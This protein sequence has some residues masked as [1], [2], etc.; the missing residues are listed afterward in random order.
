MHDT[1]G[2]S[3]ICRILT[4]E[5][6]ALGDRSYL[7]HDGTTAVVIDPQRDIDRVLDL[8]DG[9]GVRIAVVAE[10][11]VHNDYVTGGLALAERTGATYLV[12]AVEDVDFHRTPAAD[13]QRWEVGAL[14]LTAV[15]TPGHTPGHL[16][17]VLTDAAGAQRAVFTGG[18]MLFGAVGRTD[19]IGDDE[20]DGLTRAQ[21]HSVRRLAGLLDDSVEVLPTHGFG[22]FCAASPTDGAASTIGDQRGVNVALVTDDEDRFVRE[23]L[24]GLVDHPGYYTHMGPINRRGPGAPDLSL[25]HPVDARTI[26]RGLAE[27]GYV[28]DL[29]HRRAFAAGHVRGTL[30]FELSDPL[31]TYLGWTIPWGADLTLV[32]E[33]P[34]DVIEARRQLSR[35]GIDRLAGHAVGGPHDWT[36]GP[37]ASYPVASFADLAAALG[38][39]PRPVVVDVRRPD[40]WAASHIPG[41]HNVP[42]GELRDRIG[43]L[44][45]GVVWVHCA[46]GYRAAVAAGWLDRAGRDVTLVDDAWARAVEL[47]LAG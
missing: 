6:P 47:G 32:G 15:T 29:R 14:T 38:S 41:G 21:Y 18:S 9:L 46:A 39:D 22:S 26:A 42:L 45:D 16:A 31:A 34:E 13:G 5:T 2:V 8:A 12:A 43:D 4:I 36:T 19:L 25:P 7:A 37:L 17:Y 35:I 33:T 44:P 11:H 40:E 28:I 20:T 10:T 1:T 24:A 3:D 30:C 23:L 27:G